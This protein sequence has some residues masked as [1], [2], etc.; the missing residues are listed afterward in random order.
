MLGI[1]R[2]LVPFLTYGSET[3]L[4]KRKERSRIRAVQTDNLKGL[5][6]IT[7]VDRVP[8]ARI[9]KLCRVTKG[10]DERIEEGVLRWF[11]HVESMEKERIAKRAYVGDCAGSRSLCRPR[12]R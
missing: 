6:G 5:L 1:C 9:K 11:G 2:L 3:M 12:K 7:R 10:A 8:N 4:W